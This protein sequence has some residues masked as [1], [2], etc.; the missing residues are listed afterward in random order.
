MPGYNY[1]WTFI[2]SALVET[3][4]FDSR[5][6][7]DLPGAEFKIGDHVTYQE[8]L[9]STEVVISGV[10]QDGGETYNYS[11]RTLRGDL[12]PF[13]FFEWGLTFAQA[14]TALRSSQMHIY[15]F[16][17]VRNWSYCGGAIIVTAR[18]P[19]EARGAAMDLQYEPGVTYGAFGAVFYLDGEHTTR[20]ENETDAWYLGYSAPLDIKEAPAAVVVSNWNYS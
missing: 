19:E 14:P 6:H 9:I 20:V 15:V 1:T 16:E 5:N 3:R 2:M 11:V 7:K 8:G 13:C 17:P 12:F 4:G 10:R 18:S